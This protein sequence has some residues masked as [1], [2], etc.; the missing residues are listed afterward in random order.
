MKIKI[1]TILQQ[2]TNLHQ[3]HFHSVIMCFFLMC[4]LMKHLLTSLKTFMYI[5]TIKLTS[6]YP[7]ATHRVYGYN[8]GDPDNEI[9]FYSD[10]PNHDNNIDTHADDYNFAAWQNMQNE[11]CW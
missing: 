4:G 5:L 2:L 7:K 1:L 8:T 9:I 6:S 11:Y 10:E 3:L